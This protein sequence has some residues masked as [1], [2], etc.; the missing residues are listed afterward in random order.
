MGITRRDFLKYCGV[1][2]AALGL[3]RLDLLR[4]EEALAASGAPTVLWLQGA[5][6]TGCSVSFLNYID[7][8]TNPP[9]TAKDLLINSVNL[10][11]HPNL[12][13]L[14]GQDAAQQAEAAYN[15][16][17]YILAVEG[18]VPTAFNG[19]ACWAWT[20]NGMDVTFQQ[21]VHD[22]ASKAACILAVGT[23]ASFGGIPAAGANP[24]GV[25][26]VTSALNGQAT[27]NISGCPAHPDWVVWVVAQLLLGRQPGS[28]AF[29]LDGSRRPT[30]FFSQTVHSQCPRRSSDQAITFGVDNACLIYMGCQGPLTHANCP[31]QLW[32]NKKNWCIDANSRC[33]GCTE[34]GFPGSQLFSYV[35]GGNDEHSA[36]F[37]KDNQYKCG[38]CHSGTTVGGGGG[39]GGGGTAP[40][41]PHGYTV[42]NCVSCHGYV[43]PYP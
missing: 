7:N 27:V 39:G 33:L 14:A 40:P 12:M 28:A 43:P 42:N 8:S 32:N 17:G 30:Q 24:A 6:C 18:G 31:A 38:N 25:K 5:A 4:L 13:A 34:P 41:N 37:I 16:G 15:A 19:A 20:Y 22:L 10:A 11:Y 21:A 26:S 9:T 36:A 3:T 35:G 29:P 2:A 23:C 1:S